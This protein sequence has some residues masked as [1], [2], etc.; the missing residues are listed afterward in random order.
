[1]AILQEH[2]LLPRFRCRVSTALVCFGLVFLP[3]STYFFDRP[4][5]LVNKRLAGSAF[6]FVVYDFSAQVMFLGFVVASGSLFW[7]VYKRHWHAVLQ[8]ALEMVVSFG[9]FILL[10]A[11]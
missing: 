7:F 10:P 8:A 11:Y 2:Q 3:W 5:F 1:M 9:A 4:H 6:D